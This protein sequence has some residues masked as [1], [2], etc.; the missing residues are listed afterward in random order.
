[1]KRGRRRLPIRINT[2]ALITTLIRCKD[3]CLGLETSYY[4]RYSLITRSLYS[5][6]TLCPKYLLQKAKLNNKSILTKR[7]SYDW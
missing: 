3:V 5:N 2:Y 7:L 4:N 6:A 1:M